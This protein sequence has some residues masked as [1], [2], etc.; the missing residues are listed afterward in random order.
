MATESIRRPVHHIGERVLSPKCSCNEAQEPKIIPAEV[1]WQTIDVRLRASPLQRTRLQ[2][3]IVDRDV[4]ALW[5]LFGE[6]SSRSHRACQTPRQSVSR[7]GAISGTCSRIPAQSVSSALQR[8]MPAVP[9]AKFPAVRNF[10]AV[11]LVGLF[12]EATYP[13]GLALTPRPRPH[14]RAPRSVP[15]QCTHNRSQSAWVVHPARRYSL[16]LAASFTP[17]LESPPTNRGSV[18]YHMIGRKDPDDRLRLA[19]CCSSRKA[20]SAQAGAV[21]RAIGSLTPDGLAA[22]P[23]VAPRSP[24]RNQ[25]VGDHPHVASRTASGISRSR[26]CWIMVA[27]RHPARAP[28]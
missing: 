25:P 14:S 26:V 28:V 15:V 3:C 6:H 22:P 8:N 12:T 2:Q 7:I 21:L 17:A 10:S 16:P 20:V 1:C 13:E 5:E 19:P 11:V 24:P 27:S 4:L 9:G 23:A 18:C